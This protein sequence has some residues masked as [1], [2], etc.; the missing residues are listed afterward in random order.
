MPHIVIFLPPEL[1][2][3][4]EKNLCKQWSHTTEIQ[5]SVGQIHVGVE[6]LSAQWEDCF[7]GMKRKKISLWN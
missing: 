5:A 4:F 3:E 7:I 1:L 2:S 6:L